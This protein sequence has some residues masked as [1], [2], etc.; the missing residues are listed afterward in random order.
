MRHLAAVCVSIVLFGSSS[1]PAQS[2]ESAPPTKLTQYQ[3]SDWFFHHN[4]GWKAL[5]L[6]KLPKAEYC[7]NRAIEIAKIEIDA[8]PRLAARSYGDLAWVLHRESR[9]AEAQPLAKW[10]LSVREQSF[11]TD[12]MQVTQTMYTLAAIELKLNHLDEAEVLLAKTLD[13]CRL[14]LGNHTTG[15]A[16]A[17]E[18]LREHIAQDVSRAL[19]HVDGPIVGAPVIAAKTDAAR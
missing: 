18:D 16:E 12:S 1:A 8:D 17:I 14:R 6:N 3:F 5:Y 13:N 19:A 7:F 10:A 11:G 4:A 15:T 9:D 2:P